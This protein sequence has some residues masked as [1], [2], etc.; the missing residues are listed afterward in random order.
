M[1]LSSL[2]TVRRLSS[3]T[4]FA[5]MVFGLLYCW[6]L[7]AELAPKLG[8]FEK[9]CDVG[10]VGIPGAVEFSPEKNQYRIRGS[11]TN[12]WGK[13]DAFQFLWKKTSGDL[14]FSM[15]VS[16]VGAGKMGHRKACVMVRSGLDAD[17]PYA[18]IAVHGSGLIVLQYRK[19]KGGITAPVRTTIEAPATVELER[20]GNVFTA[21]VSKNGGAFEKIG[22]V[23]M[24]LP[25]PVYAG[26]AVCSHDDTVAETAIISNVVLK[27]VK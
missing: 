25:D 12:I 19:E 24:T 13:E 1:T 20:I 3:A 9:N 5:A 15:D 22:S 6:T 17:A 11:G 10:K 27:N 16:W 23:S 4:L 18:D 2:L 7:G 21:L 8:I 26:L 14:S